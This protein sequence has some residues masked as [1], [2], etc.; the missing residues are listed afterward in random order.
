MAEIGVISVANNDPDNP[1]V[2]FDAATYGKR[3]AEVVI[4]NVSGDGIPIFI[5]VQ[6]VHGTAD[7]S[8]VGDY[9]ILNPDQDKIRWRYMSS[10]RPGSP[11]GMITRVLAHNSSTLGSQD[12]ISIRYW[13]TEV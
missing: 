4:Q 12:N 13:I 8:T 7:P 2:L 5:R 10:E 9:Q 1:T 3:I 11:R 6:P